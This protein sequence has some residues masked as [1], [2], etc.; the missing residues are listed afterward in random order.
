MRTAKC[1]FVICF[2]FLQI[3][4]CAAAGKDVVATVNGHEITADDFKN[5]M[6]ISVMPSAYDDE[7][8]KKQV[9]DSMIINSLIYDMALEKGIDKDEEMLSRLND[10]KKSMA[11][12]IFIEREVLDKINLTDEEVRK[13]YDEHSEEFVVP[14]RVKASHIL[15]QVPENADE[16]VKDK[17]KKAAEDVLAR[18]KNGEKFEALAE[19]M[20]D[21]PSSKRGGDLGFFARG[22]MVPEFEDAAFDLEVGEV[23][24]VVETRFGYHIIMV[25]E[26]T[27]SEKIGFDENKDRIK[28]VL[29]QKKKNDALQKW[30][31][32]VKSKADIQINEGA[33]EEV[34]IETNDEQ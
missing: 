24:R 21:C 33:I 8:V 31:E 13:Y 6:K 20:S 25:T 5:K 32:E 30:L 12:Q 29:L 1:F 9:L 14:E 7:S 15:I 18:I 23:S 3:S 34:K 28:Q 27:P 16:E 22:Q 17:A 11:S 2:M 4:A 10:I 19:E 26:K